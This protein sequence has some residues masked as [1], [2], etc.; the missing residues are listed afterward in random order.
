MEAHS[1]L[2]AKL[3]AEAGF[4]ALWGSGLAISAA[5]GVRDNNEA[6][7]TQVLEVLEFMA[8]ATELPILLD[9]DTGYG[10]FNNVRRLVRKL[11]Q[12]NIAGVCLEDKL[13]PKTNSFIDGERQALAEVDEF[14]GKLNAAKDTQRDPDF[15]VVARTEAFIAGWGLEEAVLRATAYAEAGADLILVH[16]K[17][18]DS[19][20]IIA[21]MQRWDQRVPVV[22]VPT[23]YPTEP[24]E[25]FVQAGI[26]N[27]IFANHALRTVVTA[28]QRN[29]GILR[30]T[31]DLM[32]IENEIAPVS[33]VFRLQNV[34]ELKSSEERYLPST[35]N[36]QEVSGLVLAASKG[37]F[38]ELVKD[39]PK[40]ML[41]LRGKPIM[42]WHTDAFRRQ[43]IRRIGAVRGYC[44]QA[45]DLADI[46]YFDND[47]YATTGELASLYAARDF[48][49][50]DVV[51]AYGDIVF[52]EFILR[53]LLSQGGEIS[54]AV[55]GGWKL[56][57][58]TDE[59]RDLVVTDGAY[60]PMGLSTCKLS[61]IGGV[62]PADATGEWI[63]LLHLRA[64]K[65]EK[66]VKLLD[67]FAKEEPETL[68]KGDIP[69]LLNRLV[70]A[71][72]TVSVVHTFGHWYDLDEQ[73]DLLLA[74]AQVKS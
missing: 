9:G 73:K 30:S 62:K 74:S 47:D 41:R 8:D 39:R 31:L 36:R 58:R 34:Q 52:D 64:E 24:I 19:K 17:R 46:Q 16:S 54:I 66:L 33:E 68:R 6:S 3:A 61:R 69:G 40:A 48:L 55:D 32:S 29:L 51:I 2:S 49:R 26:T 20:E 21:F 53:N 1:G 45:I 71:G 65:T 37:D 35:A 60:D 70:A 50:G 56:R 42:T 28:L 5:L 57:Q 43:G 7:W 59:R 14:C 63:G 11:E 25:S 13:F 15:V 4:E 72:E 27:F 23:K 67:H 38:G 44:K 10:N 12:R 22:I 18:K